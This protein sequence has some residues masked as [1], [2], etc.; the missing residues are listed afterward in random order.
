MVLEA[1]APNS[2]DNN[3]S[4]I[5]KIN[6]LRFFGHI[7]QKDDDNLERLIVSGNLEGRNTQRALTNPMV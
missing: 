7:K 1:L 5:R 4:I 6:S 3:V 2:V